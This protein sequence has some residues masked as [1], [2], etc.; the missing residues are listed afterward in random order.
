LGFKKQ[1][2]IFMS[3]EIDVK[4][5]LIKFLKLPKEKQTL[6]VGFIEGVQYEEIEAP[7]EPDKEEVTA[8]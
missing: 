5:T 7:K 8:V 1:E 2:M 4:R 3:K 6:V